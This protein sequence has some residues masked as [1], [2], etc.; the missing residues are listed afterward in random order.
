MTNIDERS[1]KLLDFI[2]EP[3]EL[4]PALIPYLSESENGWLMIRHPLVYSIVHSPP[5]NKLVNAQLRA[6]RAAVDLAYDKNDWHSYIWLH[7]RPY[8]VDAFQEI[9]EWMS[10]EQY[11]SLLGDIW[12]D[13]E[14]IRQNPD[15]WEELLNSERPL[16]AFIMDDDERADLDDMPAVITVY[17]GHTTV[18]DD[19]W[20]WTTERETALWFAHRFANLEQ[21]TAALSTGTVNKADVLAYFTGRNESEILVERSLVTI[22]NT[23]MLL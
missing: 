22:T 7:E 21:G 13:S 11:W 5:L 17:Q 23:A 14:N 19:G 1:Q 8:R 9:M 6:K 18:R 15:E 12:I 2:G 16:R 20:S 4:D 10:D 3:E